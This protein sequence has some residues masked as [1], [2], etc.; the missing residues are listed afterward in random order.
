MILKDS[1][2]KPATAFKRID[3][4]F[5]DSTIRRLGRK[6]R[7]KQSVLLSTAREK[8]IGSAVRAAERP[9]RDVA[10]P[11]IGASND[12][13]AAV[14]MAQPFEQRHAKAI[15]AAARFEEHRAKAVG[16]ALRFDQQQA[17]AIEAAKRFDQAHAL[18]V[19]A[20]L[21]RINKE[22]AQAV[23]RTRDGANYA[24][25]T[26]IPLAESTQTLQR[27]AEA[28]LSPWQPTIAGLAR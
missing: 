7:S 1:S 28:R 3:S 22:I 11:R 19:G 14:V 21:D 23:G 27:I 24:S 20:A 2:L 16:A 17:N 8:A 6:W 18:A 10:Q 5:G 15:E 13:L 4:T 12:Y 25:L 9:F 26:T